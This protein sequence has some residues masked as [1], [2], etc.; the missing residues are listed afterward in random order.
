MCFDE[1]FTPRNDISGEINKVLEDLSFKSAFKPYEKEMIRATFWPLRLNYSYIL[2]TDAGRACFKDKRIDLNY[3]LLCKPENKDEIKETFLHEL[4]HFI[5][6][7]V[8]PTASAHGLEFKK[9]LLEI[10]GDG[11][12]CHSMDVPEF[13]VQREKLGSEGIWHPD[14]AA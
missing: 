5:T 9:I 10:G 14:E 4:A 3:R 12:T 2:G 7:V 11:T 13:L 1:D 6:W 8:H